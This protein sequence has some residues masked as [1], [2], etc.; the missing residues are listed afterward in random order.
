MRLGKQSLS[1]N[2]GEN[3]NWYNPFGM[4]SRKI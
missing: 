2:I 3:A 4:E 1:Y